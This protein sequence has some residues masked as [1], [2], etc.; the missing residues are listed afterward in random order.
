MWKRSS[1]RLICIYVFILA[2]NSNYSI[3]ED[4]CMMV[5]AIVALGFLYLSAAI[6]I[7]SFIFYFLLFTGTFHHAGVSDTNTLAP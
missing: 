3:H 1:A 5:I 6:Q 7:V 4:L 2:D